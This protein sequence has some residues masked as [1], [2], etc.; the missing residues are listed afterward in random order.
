MG[1]ASSLPDN[2]EDCTAL[3]TD[4]SNP[5]PVQWN[6]TDKKCK[7]FKYSDE[8]RLGMSNC[9]AV[10]MFDMSNNTC[11]DKL[12][13]TSCEVG[14]Y[15]A[16]EGSDCI[17]VPDSCGVGM[18]RASEG[19]N[20]IKVPDSSADESTGDKN[21]EGFTNKAKLSNRDVMIL[22][23]LVVLMCMYRKELKQALSKLKK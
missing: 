18:Y 7:L 13:D 21:T 5:K 2:E 1:I 9:T 6:S 4:G 10:Q 14:M 17:K 20:C 22:I 11:S 8:T 16:S 3:R 15:R 19:S 23:I 12:V